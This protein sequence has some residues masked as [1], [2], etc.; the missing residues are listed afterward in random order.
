VDVHSPAKLISDKIG[1]DFAHPSKE[2]FVEEEQVEPI[3]ILGGGPAGLAAAYIL[4]QQGCSVVVVERSSGVGG[5]AKSVEHQ[6]FIL[7]LGPHRFSTEVASVLKLWNEVLGI[8]Q[9]TINRLTRIYYGRRYFRYPFKFSEVMLALGPINFFKVLASYVKTRLLP[10][11]DPKS[12]AEWVTSKFGKRLFEIFFEAYTEKLWGISCTEISPEWAAQRINGSSLIQALHSAIF[13]DDSQVETSTQSFQYPRLGTGQL[14]EKIYHYL[15][16]Q[17]QKVLLNTEV[18]GIH[19]EHYKVTHLTLRNHQTG[20][21]ETVACSSV[22]SSIPLNLLLTQLT[23]AAPETILKEAKS[24]K[25]RNAVLVYLVVDKNQLFPDNWLYINEPNTRLGRVTNFANWSPH[26]L[27]NQH[28]TP[29]CC[30]YWCDCND[31]MWQQT[32]AELLVQTE[33]ELRKIGLL[34]DEKISSGFVVRLSH[35]YPV[36]SGDYRVALLQLQAYLNQFQNLQLAGRYGTFKH[37]TQAQSLLMGILAAEN[38]LNP[39]MH[40]LW[41]MSTNAAYQEESVSDSMAT[42][43]KGLQIIHK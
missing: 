2:S 19:H 1:I 34:R 29:L 39:G 6:G 42:P 3:Y 36:Y 11:D 21:K 20:Q 18:I 17:N 16:R 10:N 41:S 9:V 32:E 4:T 24:L 37:N 14:Y 22:I 15:T 27:P 43:L 38:V 35:V 12:F 23:P 7:D 31:P 30:E 5:F 40:D 28:Q 13:S 26:L 33:A 8:D 25:F